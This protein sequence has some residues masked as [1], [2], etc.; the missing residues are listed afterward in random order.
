MKLLTAALL[1]F[2]ALHLSGAELP[3]VVARFGK[4]ELRKERFQLFNLP[5]EGESRRQMLKKLVDTEVRL[6]IVRDLL[7]RSGIAPDFLTAKRYIDMRRKQFAGKVPEA[8]FKNLEKNINHNSFRLKCAL[9][10]T[11][12]AADPK[13]V[14]PAPEDIRRHYDLN[15]E[16][17]RKPVETLLSMF[18]AGKP[19]AEGKKNASLI[20]ARLRQGEDFYAL[21]A[22]FDPEGHKK[23][24]APAPELRP[25]FKKVREMEPGAVE[26]VET[27]RGIFIVKVVSKSAPSFRPL[28]ETLLYVTET[29]S[30]RKL[31]ASLEQYMR[32]ILAKTP[33][34]YCF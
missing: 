23:N 19:L 5:S 9:Y 3:D 16:Q 11:F 4:V 22:Q 18:R 29:L 20:L 8:Q 14:E 12:Y 10:F 34:Q 24:A 27:P 26:A 7:S 2:F 30:S 6:M 21:A 1:F 31:K 32:E 13:T 15:R 33:V 28:S 25:Y 17:F